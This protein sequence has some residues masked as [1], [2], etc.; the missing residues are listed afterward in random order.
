M[1]LFG[2][3]QLGNFINEKH[4]KE[5]DGDLQF[6]GGKQT[7]AEWQQGL[8]ELC[9]KGGVLWLALPWSSETWEISFWEQ[10]A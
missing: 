6:H 3:L 4:I 7:K 10:S 5:K 2:L 8:T 9:G 1:I